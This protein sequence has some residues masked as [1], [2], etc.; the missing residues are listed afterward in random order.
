MSSISSTIQKSILSLLLSRLPIYLDEEATSNISLSSGI[1]LTNVTLD[2]DKLQNRMPPNVKYHIRSAKAEL[3]DIQVGTNGINAKISG[4][5]VVISPKIDASSLSPSSSFTDTSGGEEVVQS[6]IDLMDVVT[7]VNTDDINSEYFDDVND[8]END[9]IIKY[10]IKS[11]TI[12]KKDINGQNTWTGYVLS[13]I[14][15]KVKVTLIDIKVKALAEN[16]V[17]TVMFDKVEVETD[18]GNRKCLIEGIRLGILRDEKNTSNDDDQEEEAEK[19]DDEE[20]VYD[21]DDEYNNMMASSFIV[22]SKEQIQRSLMESFNYKKD[23]MASTTTSD[24]FFDAESHMVSSTIPGTAPVDFGVSES[25]LFIEHISLLID[26]TSSPFSVVTDIGFINGTLKYTPQILDSVIALLKQNKRRQITKAHKIPPSVEFKSTKSKFLIH[27]FSITEVNISLDSKINHKGMFENNDES[28]CLKLKELSIQ[29]KG[30]SFYQG[31]LMKFSVDDGSRQ[32]INFQNEKNTHVDFKFEI[33]RIDNVKSTSVICSNKLNFDVNVDHLEHVWKFYNTLK[34]LLDTITEVVT[35]KSANAKRGISL[36]TKRGIP[37]M[38]INKIVQEFNF[39]LSGIEG[40]LSLPGDDRLNF[41]TDSLDYNNLKAFNMGIINIEFNDQD[42]CHLKEIALL[43]CLEN[44]AKVKGYDNNTKNVLHLKAKNVLHVGLIK[45]SNDF[46]TF[47]KITNITKRIKEKFSQISESSSKVNFDMDTARMSGSMFLKSSSVDFYML[48]KKIEIDILN[49]KQDFGGLHCAISN[50]C[51]CKHSVG[52]MNGFIENIET[53]RMV[54][55]REPLISRANYLD[56]ASPMIIFKLQPGIPMVELQNWQLEYYGQWLKIF[57][58]QVGVDKYDEPVNVKQIQ[59]ILNEKVTRKIVS[60]EVFI[61]L[62]DFVLGLSPVNLKSQALIYMKRATCDTVCYNDKTTVAQLSSERVDF[63]LIDDKSNINR[64]DSIVGDLKQVLVSSGFVQIGN[65]DS[66]NVK[67]NINTLKSIIKAKGSSFRPIIEIQ[68]SINDLE[69]GI[70]SDSLQCFLNMLKDL[71][72]P[73][74]FSYDDKYKPELSENLNIFQGVEDHFF[75]NS[76]S[77]ESSDKNLDVG[78]N[79]NDTENELVFIEDY[80]ETSKFRK[81]DS[82]IPGDHINK[83]EI[84]PIAVYVN[85]SKTEVLL[86]DGYDWKE[87]RTQISEAVNRVKNKVRKDTELAEEFT[88]DQSSSTTNKSLGDDLDEPSTD[89]VVEETLYQSIY[90]GMHKSSNAQDFVQNINV[91]IHDDYPIR[92]VTSGSN[93]RTT[94]EL[95]KKSKKSKT[96]KLKRTKRHKV[97]IEIESIVVELLI[98]TSNEPHIGTARPTTFDKW[99]VEPIQRID[100]GIKK[101]KIID[102]LVTSNWNMF[103]GYLREAGDIEIGKEMLHLKIEMYRPLNKLGAIEMVM[104]VHL[105]PLRLHVDQDTLDFLLRFGEFKDQ[106]FIVPPIDDDEM[107]ISK[108]DINSIRLKLDYKPKVIDYG[109][110]RSGHTEE[111]VN[112]FVLDESR[113]TLNKLTLFG[114]YGFQSLNK[115]LNGYWSPDI[116]KNQLGGVLSGLSF[117]R[118][119]VNIGQGVENIVSEPYKEVKRD[120]QIIRGFQRGVYKFGKTTGGEVLKFGVKLAAG[121]QGILESTEEM[122]GG[123]GRAKVGVEEDDV[124]DEQQRLHLSHH[125]VNTFNIASNDE[126]DDLIDSGGSDHQELP[127]NE[128][129]DDGSSSDEQEHRVVSLYSNQPGTLQEGIQVAYGSIARNMSSMRQAVVEAGDR[130]S[131]SD[132]LSGALT[133]LARAAPVVVIRPL[134]ATSEAISKTLMGGVNAMDPDQKRSLEEKYK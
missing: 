103:L 45:I 63:Y 89:V 131:R 47:K 56:K 101:F 92:S 33:Q 55:P 59:T 86:Y 78:S 95:G 82:V 60:F 54:S 15:S 80:Y 44:N 130:A 13:Y 124:D 133:E 53:S 8:E 64:E 9:E 28:L 129:Y 48:I 35:S 126:D 50:A 34:P 102:N 100:V 5:N 106:R 29:Q 65:V 79:G 120:G 1:H 111:F 14:L 38:P 117:L 40:R 67:I 108:F 132:T 109:G 3:I 20:N 62:N 125:T 85:V 6:V 104:N 75:K 52:L 119:I 21:E 23:S 17:F 42:I 61:G 58:E 87:T 26:T 107:F 71:K 68:L 2:E 49:I 105:L 16:H 25:L 91:Q 115:L 31:S 81:D 121:T 122:L 128:E 74:F 77:K 83:L 69:I 24:A 27:D 72:Q 18:K 110:I 19:E 32:V 93:K 37:P 99:K 114:V 88:G 30:E 118:S 66:L 116:K 112:F 41:K 76:Q 113:M 12:S 97:K 11:N 84:Y 96:L 22:E 4:C 123:G 90:V 73:I 134:I 127:V 57:D 39:S 43:N 10:M 46:D 7:N 36:N 98:L 51:L 94:V 70:C